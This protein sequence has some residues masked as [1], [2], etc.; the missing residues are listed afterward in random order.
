MKL[1]LLDDRRHA[2]ARKQDANPPW[3]VTGCRLCQ[4]YLP[5][6]IFRLRG[7]PRCTVA[8][9]PASRRV[10]TKTKNSR[11]PARGSHEASSPD[12]VSRPYCRPV[13]VAGAVNSFKMIT[14]FSLIRKNF[15]RL[16]DEGRHGADRNTAAHGLL[17][18]IAVREAKASQQVVVAM[19]RRQRSPVHDALDG[20]CAIL[21]VLDPPGGR[22]HPCRASLP[23]GARLFLRHLRGAG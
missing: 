9:S 3:F 7:G 21:L 20:P 22:H 17:A 15:I 4:P 12:T 5:T 18:Q 2:G 10:D 1:R 23:A 11:N 19:G 6:R 13:T 16:H 8:H 14:L